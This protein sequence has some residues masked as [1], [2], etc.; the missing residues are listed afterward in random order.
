MASNIE[1]M[2]AQDMS[3]HA[4]AAAH[5]NAA[6]HNAAL[7]ALAAWYADIRTTAQAVELV[8]AGMPAP[9]PA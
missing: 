2:P 7:N 5:A 6:E 8:R 1:S 4:L 3:L 9:A